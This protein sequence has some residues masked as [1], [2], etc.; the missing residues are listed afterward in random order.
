MPFQY[1]GLT[2]PA[3]RGLKA[4]NVKV[5]GI[6]ETIRNLRKELPAIINIKIAR[7][8]AIIGVDLLANSMPRVPV[9]T[10]EL[11]RSG[12]AFVRLGKRRFDVATGTEEGT[13]KAD[14]GVVTS[15]GMGNVRAMHLDVAFY[16]MG[17]QGFDVAQWTHENLLAHEQRSAGGPPAARTP[18][19]GPK[20]LE[21]PW[22]EKREAYIALLRGELTRGLERDIQ[23]A[24]KVR[25]RRVG[26]YEVDVVELVHNRIA[27]KGYFHTPGIIERHF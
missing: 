15:A 22:K 2:Q 26:K 17:N 3:G 25:Q 11:R 18:G 6:E 21:L 23:L 13:V 20:Y 1:P 8:L 16:R 10:G 27:K 5:I 9:D 14:L 4:S 7:T 19:T 12:V 24:S